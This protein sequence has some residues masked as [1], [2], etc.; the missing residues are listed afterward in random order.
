MFCGFV[1]IV[2]L[3]MV[4][5]ADFGEKTLLKEIKAI[6]LHRGQLTS[7]RRTSPVSQ[8]KCDGG[9]AGCRVRQPATTQCYNRGTYGNDIQWECLAELDYKYKFGKIEVVCEGYEYPDDPYIL[10]GSCGLEYTIDYTGK[11]HK[12][13]TESIGGVFL[14]IFG[15]A[16]VGLCCDTSPRFR[17]PRYGS[18]GG[19]SFLAGAATGMAVNSYYRSRG[20]GGYSSSRTSSG[21]GGTRRR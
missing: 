11:A 21:F 15:L 6:T 4:V 19:S 1:R 3:A 18:T 9:G 7:G 12:K 5:H 20:G 8:M 14:F 16:M 10:S 13:N 2:I 17:P